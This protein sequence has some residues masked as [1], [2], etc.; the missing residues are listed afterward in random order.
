MTE[1]EPWRPQVHLSGSAAVDL[2]TWAQQMQSAGS[3]ARALAPTEFVPRTLRKSD[4]GAT[5]A[6]VAAAVLTGK[7]VGLEPMAA[8]RSI[9]VIEGSP[10]I[11]AVAMRALVLHAGHDMWV[12]ESTATRAIV[13]GVRNGSTHEQRSTWTLDRAKVAGLAGKPNWRSHPGAM[14]V[15]RATAECARLIAPDV[16]LGLPYSTEELADGDLVAEDG[17][18]ENTEPAKPPARRTA[19]RRTTKAITPAAPPPTAETNS[20]PPPSPID[21][22]PPFDDDPPVDPA[23][24]VPQEQAPDDVDQDQPD[25]PVPAAELATEGMIRQITKAMGRAGIRSAS[26]QLRAI[27]RIIGRAVTHPDQLY[28][29]EVRVVLEELARVAE[30][31]PALGDS[32]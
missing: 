26:G 8:L 1:L 3:I 23:D 29:A 11:R 17:P 18:G 30:K 16:L 25:D 28:R 14:L 24:D 15:A 13:A 32:R 7:E 5:A 22:P 20:E 21:S 6:A 4:P 10:A 31:Q 2:D 27:E 12:E 19:Q 9:D